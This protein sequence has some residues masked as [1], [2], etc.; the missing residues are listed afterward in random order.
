MSQSARLTA[1]LAITPT[2][3]QVQ[4]KWTADL[5]RVGLGVLSEATSVLM[6]GFNEDQIIPF[7]MFA[8]EEGVTV[9]FIEFM[10]LEEDR[11]WSPATV[12]TL[13]EK[14]RAWPSTGHWSKFRMRDRR[15]RGATALKTA[16]GKSA[17]SRRFRVRSA[18]TAAAFASPPTARFEPAVRAGTTTCTRKCS[19]ARATKSCRNRSRSHR[20]ERRT[21]SYRRT[22]FRAGIW[23]HRAHW[24]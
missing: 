15:R 2:K 18:D 6:R 20:E 11:T 5:E 14:P 23:N 13:D 24:G 19:A 10:P 1:S 22:G 21:A 3:E 17:L 7:G 8:R 4:Y 9:R 12:V 16:S